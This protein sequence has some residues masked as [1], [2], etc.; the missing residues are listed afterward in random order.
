MNKSNMRFSVTWL[1]LFN[2]K[3]NT[4]TSP[5]NFLTKVMKAAN[6]CFLTC[7]N[8]ELSQ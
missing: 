5:K 1:E 4:D 7:R 2:Q 3:T 8:I 6:Q